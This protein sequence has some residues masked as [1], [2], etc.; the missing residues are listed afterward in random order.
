MP[1]REEMI[2]E[3]KRRDMIEQLQKQ[4][5]QLSARPPEKPRMGS[6]ETFGAGALSGATMDL[7]DEARGVYGGV[8]NIVTGAGDFGSGY[9]EQ[10]NRQRAW[11][12][13]AKAADPDL[14]FGG[15]L[16]GGIGSLLIPGGAGIRGASAAGRIGSAAARGAGQG[17]VSGFGTSRAED[18]SD[19]A[20]DTG[21]GGLIGA[22]GGAGFQGGAETLRKTG[23]ADYLAQRMNPQYVAKKVG[24]AF[25][26]APEEATERYMQ[27]PDLVNAAPERREITQQMLGKLDESKRRIV[28][29]SQKSRDIL[30]E[31]L[32]TV[33]GW[34]IQRELGKV[35]KPLRKRME[36]VEDDPERLA[37]LMDLE[38]RA[39]KYG[40]KTVSGSRV[41]DLVQS[42]QKGA[43]YEVQAGKFARPDKYTM[44]EAAANMNAFLKKN[45]PGYAEEM[46]KVAGDT[47]AHNTFSDMFQTDKGL[48]NLFQRIQKDRSFGELEKLQAYDERFGTD[49]VN[50]LKDS[51]AREAFDKGSTQ[52]SRKVNYFGDIAENLPEPLKFGVKSFGMVADPYGPK[53]AKMSIDAARN[54]D[55]WLNNNGWMLG[56]SQRAAIK[57]I[58]QQR[59]PEAAARA[60]YLTL[61]N[62]PGSGI[63]ED[64]P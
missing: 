46:E 24:K 27:R 38:A 11:K 20:V 4:D 44:Q 53:I 19:L 5:Q 14:Y 60:L 26:G 2:R 62:D 51:Y 28:E 37:A 25:L 34:E 43:D 64:G 47:T 63:G 31:E 59:G 10:R 22:A 32:P 50:Q 41:K 30:A 7:D 29:G 39:G 16:T 42:L 3:L 21:V 13:E 49:F 56:Q 18:L 9:E 52:G 55:E 57:R 40:G 33:E 6:V 15:E 1:S 36:G 58:A 8:K 61:K 35:T 48:D 54:I 17:V 45:S 12:D 23:I